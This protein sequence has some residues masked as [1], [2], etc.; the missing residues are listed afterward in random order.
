VATLD[1]AGVVASN[2]V[3]SN[4]AAGSPGL[5]ITATSTTPKNSFMV[6]GNIVSGAVLANGAALSPTLK[7][8]NVIG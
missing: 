5:T 8:L 3:L 1:A 7:A 4:P 2:N 6:L